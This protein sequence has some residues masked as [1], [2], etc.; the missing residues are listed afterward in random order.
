MMTR[1]SYKLARFGYPI[2]TALCTGL[3]WGRAGPPRREFPLDRTYPGVSERRDRA[4]PIAALATRM[5]IYSQEG[6]TE[7][8]G[9]MDDFKNRCL[10]SDSNRLGNAISVMLCMGH[11][12]LAKRRDM[13][14]TLAT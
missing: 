5:L 1:P 12:T 10:E 8:S 11:Q 9:A 4:E 6:R 7:L 3:S 14:L 13:S 2:H